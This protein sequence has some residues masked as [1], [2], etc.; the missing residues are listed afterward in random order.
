[1][2]DFDSLGVI[3]RTVRPTDESSE[4]SEGGGQ[5][6]M[7]SEERR[8]RLLEL[9]R[10]RG[11]ASLPELSSEMQVS[12]STIRRDLDFLGGDGRGQADAWRRVLHRALAQAAAF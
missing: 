12:P 11:F 5:E 9:V 8:S 6:T 10:Q 7:T 3:I 1:M 4:L 2:I